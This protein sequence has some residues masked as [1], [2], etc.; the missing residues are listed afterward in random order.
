MQEVHLL[1]TEMCRDTCESILPEICVHLFE[2][3]CMITNAAE[4]MKQINVCDA[5]QNLSERETSP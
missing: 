5:V 2:K 3:M 4:C 1:I